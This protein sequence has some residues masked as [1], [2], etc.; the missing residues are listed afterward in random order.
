MA[1][2]NNGGFTIWQDFKATDIGF[3]I[4]LDTL[5]SRIDDE[6]GGNWPFSKPFRL[7]WFLIPAVK[8]MLH[9]N[10]PDWI[11]HVKSGFGDE[12]FTLNHLVALV[13]DWL[14]KN[15]HLLPLKGWLLPMLRDLALQFCNSVTI[16][17]SMT[18][19]VYTAK[20]E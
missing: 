15:K 13:F 7:R 8:S 4:Y 20:P 10:F 19:W 5:L 18:R 14:E 9:T 17:G 2:T 6:K 1:D 11:Q 16:P 3:S 12:K